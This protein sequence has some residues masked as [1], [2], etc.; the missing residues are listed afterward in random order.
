MLPSLTADSLRRRPPRRA[1]LGAS[2][3]VLIALNDHIEVALQWLLLALYSIED[4][5]LE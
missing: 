1:V 3:A 4:R 2:G 5:V